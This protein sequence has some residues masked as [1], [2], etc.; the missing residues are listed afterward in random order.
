M[1]TTLIRLGIHL[2]ERYRGLF[3]GENPY[4]TRIWPDRFCLPV[5]TFHNL[6]SPNM[7][8]QTRHDL[9]NPN[10][11]VLWSDLWTLFHA[12]DLAAMIDRPIRPNVDH[13]GQTDEWA[14]ERVDVDHVEQCAK[15]CAHNRDC[16]A[17]T[18]E[19]DLK[20]C[21]IAPFIIVGHEHPVVFSGVASSRALKPMA[22]C[23]TDGEG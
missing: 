7:T 2:D 19:E 23:Q 20:S 15:W 6:Q 4:T 22:E 21:N 9:Q 8:R 1:A 10:E 14:R 16:L 5:V 18:W 3:N 13:V 17:W 11:T 12:P